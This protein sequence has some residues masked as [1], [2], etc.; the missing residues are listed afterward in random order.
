MNP[1]PEFRKQR[2]LEAIELPELGGHGELG[3]D[4]RRNEAHA[5]ANPRDG[6]PSL[7]FAV[8]VEDI[9]WFGVQ[10]KGIR[11]AGFEYAGGETMP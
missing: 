7:D 4:G 10:V 6:A 9:G 8:H 11:S 2:Y 3:E 1:T 5:V